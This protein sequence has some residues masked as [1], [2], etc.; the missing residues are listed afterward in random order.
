MSLDIDVIVDRRRYAQA[1][2]SGA[3]LPWDSPSLR[4]SVV[5][6]VATPGAAARS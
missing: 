3:W 6:V 4:S 2:L 1:D 5:G